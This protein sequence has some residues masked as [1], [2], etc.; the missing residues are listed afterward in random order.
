MRSGAARPA[1]VAAAAAGALPILSFVDF[2][3]A[4]AEIGAVQRL[5]GARGI[6][7]R[8]FHETEAAW[9]TRITIRDQ[10][11]FLDDSVSREQG[12]HGV[13][14]RREGEISNV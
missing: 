1:A 8:H 2:E 4:A 9:T 12:A 13:F 5:H 11:N 7:I 14:G 3:G 10:S 6:G